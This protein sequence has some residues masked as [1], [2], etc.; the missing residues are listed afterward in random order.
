MRV[1]L[2]WMYFLSIDS[3]LQILAQS[4]EF[5]AGKKALVICSVEMNISVRQ[6]RILL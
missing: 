5:T 4:I 1:N 6:K 2:E 3:D